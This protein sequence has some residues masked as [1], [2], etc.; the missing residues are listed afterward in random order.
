MA[1]PTKTKRAY[2]KTGKYSKKNKSKKTP[3]ARGRKPN[4]FVVEK[5]TL[6][7]GRGV[8]DGKMMNQFISRVTNLPV[9]QRTAVLI[10][11]SIAPTHKEAMAFFAVAK[12]KLAA[13]SKDYAVSSKVV[14]DNKGNYQGLRVWRL[15]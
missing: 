15:N 9:D 4:P 6:A 12:R 10:P 7:S 3:S 11:T 8:S 1:N 2:N 14:K 5:V 13:D